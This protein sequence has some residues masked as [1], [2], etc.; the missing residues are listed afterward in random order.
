[1]RRREIEGL[2]LL[3]PGFAPAYAAFVALGDRVFPSAD[4]ARSNRM[5]HAAVYFLG[6]EG[7]SPAELALVL[8]WIVI[9]VGGVALIAA[10]YRLI[11]TTSADSPPLR[12]VDVPA[13]W[14]RFD[15]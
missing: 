10:G 14:H 6:P 7:N 13:I 4:V 9:G 12:P 8:G 5:D 1:M 11:T 3:V 15:V 2:A